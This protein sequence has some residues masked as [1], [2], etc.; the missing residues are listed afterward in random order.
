MTPFFLD[1]APAR[2]GSEL[3][4]VVAVAIIIIAVVTVVA[5]AVGIFVFVR[6]RR[7]R[8]APSVGAGWAAP[9]SNSPPGPNA[10]TPPR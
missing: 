8:V 10:A 5:V 2:S 1:L 7:K 4:V 3:L 9:P 6:V